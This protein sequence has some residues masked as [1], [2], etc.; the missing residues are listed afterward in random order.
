MKT[1][2][3]LCIALMAAGSVARAQDPLTEARDLYAAA[4]Y[5]EALLQL[6]R[7][8]EAG[9]GLT[10][11]REIEQYR[12]FCLFALGRT[13]EAEATLEALIRKDPFMALDRRDASPRIDTMFASVRERLLPGLIREEYNTARALVQQK[14]PDAATSLMRVKGMLTLAEQGEFWDNTL[15]DLRMLVDGFLELQNVAVD[16]SAP[17]PSASP[18]IAPVED[19]NTS[20]APA[21][22][23][24]ASPAGTN[25]VRDEGT[26]GDHAVGTSGTVLE[27]PV[28]ISQPAPRIPSNLRAFIPSSTRIGTYDVHIT[29]SGNVSDV[30]VRQSVSPTYDTLF[31]RT[32]RTWKYRPAMRDGNPVV[33]VKT[34]TVSAGKK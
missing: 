20:P 30:V 9:A 2:H 6:D 19:L 28:A 33:S 8:G 7:A 14:S 21:A 31:V 22:S 16:S 10:A 13:R 18:A 32:A 4:S 24:A 15:A 26:S 11:A 27:P 1:A 5:E 17:A 25:A 23:N 3:L 29:E 34:I 12:A